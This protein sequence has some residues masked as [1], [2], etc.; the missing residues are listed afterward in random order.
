[1]K[2]VVVGD[3]HG[4]YKGFMQALQR[5]N[6]DYEKD[7]LYSVGDLV[8]GHSQSFEVIE[9]LLKIKN[10]ILIIGNHDEWFK[11]WIRSGE[12]P[13]NWGQGQNATALSYIKNL[14]D[15]KITE[16]NLYTIPH[17]IKPKDIP[18]SHVELLESQVPYYQDKDNNLFVHGGFNRHT[19]IEE[20]DEFVFY[21][22]RDLWSQALSF[23]AMVK[24]QMGE[25][26]KD[27]Q[28]KFKINGDFKEIFLGHTQTQF[29][30]ESTPMN[31]ANIWNMDTGGGWF[32][33]VTIMDIKTKEYW[34]SDDARSL[35]PEF[36]G[37]K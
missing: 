24:V 18:E 8:D 35:Y 3:I 16:A 26:S 15:P 22:D 34:Q 30:G 21:W 37:R 31:A 6:F 25:D 28:P 2:E 11:E 1:M 9:E 32:G 33:H 23:K 12:N 5:S 17:L 29:W 20:Q 36:K 13:T 7:M 14:I 19:P 4:N 27:W 10:K